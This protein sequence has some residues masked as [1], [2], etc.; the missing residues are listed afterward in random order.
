MLTEGK[1]AFDGRTL[2]FT[3]SVDDLGAGIVLLRRSDRR[4]LAASWVIVIGMGMLGAYTVVD[5]QFLPGIGLIG[6]ALFS[7]ALVHSGWLN[8]RMVK[9]GFSHLIGRPVTLTLDDAGLHTVV[10]GSKSTLEWPAVHA[11]LVDRRVLVIALHQ[12]ASWLIIPMT[13]FGGT[14]AIARFRDTV[15]RY[16]RLARSSM[17]P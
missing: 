14:E 4:S 12:N 2:T 17:S 8:G 3:T 9:G 10:G 5:R 6:G 1:V 15:R 11:I 16:R 13:A 7:V